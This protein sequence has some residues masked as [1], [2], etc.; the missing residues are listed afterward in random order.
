MDVSEAK[1]IIKG[2]LRRATHRWDEF[3]SRYT[4]SAGA[5][6]PVFKTRKKFLRYIDEVVQC[7]GDL[8]IHKISRQ[9][10]ASWHQK[11]ELAAISSEYQQVEGIGSVVNIALTFYDSR[12]FFK[13]N[14]RNS[15]THYLSRLYLHEH[16]LERVVLRYGLSGIGQIGKFVYPVLHALISHF[17]SMK[18]MEDHFYVV[19]ELAVLAMIKSQQLNGVVL[20]TILLR[21]RFDATQTSLFAPAYQR[22]SEQGVDMLLF[23]PQSRRTVA[24]DAAQD[25]FL[26]DKTRC[27]NTFWLHNLMHDFIEQE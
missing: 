26:L 1:A 2:A 17:T 20:K 8:L 15:Y 4:R 16:F 5:T 7:R 19:T 10:P 12:Q 22:L 6:P 23:F 21:D 11:L 25:S 18:N 14:V 27:T 9:Q 13:G 3:E 24:V